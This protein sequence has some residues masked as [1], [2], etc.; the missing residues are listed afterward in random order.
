MFAFKD[1]NETHWCNV[2][3]LRQNTKGSHK[4]VCKAGFNGDGKNYLV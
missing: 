3:A 2:N 4:C 1:I